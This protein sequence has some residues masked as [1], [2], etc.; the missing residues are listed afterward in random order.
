MVLPVWLKNGAPK[1]PGEMGME[2]PAGNMNFVSPVMF[3]VVT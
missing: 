3:A 1:S 2:L